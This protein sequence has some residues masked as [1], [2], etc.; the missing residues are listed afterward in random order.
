[1]TTTAKPP[2]FTLTVPSVS[3]GFKG[4]AP[5]LTV[6]TPPEYCSTWW[7]YDTRVP[8]TVWSDTQHNTRK[9][10]CQASGGGMYKPGVC[11]DGQELKQVNVIVEDMASTSLEPIHQGYCCPTN[12]K[13]YSNPTAVSPSCTSTLPGPVTATIQGASN[14][15]SSTTILSSVVT[16]VGE[17]I[18]LYWSSADLSLFQPSLAASLRVAMGLP[19]STSTSTSGSQSTPTSPASNQTSTPESG[20]GSSRSL[21]K[22]AIAG[23]SIGAALAALAFGFFGY[24]ASRHRSRDETDH[25]AT[26]STATMPSR[27]S[28]STRASRYGWIYRWR[29]KTVAET[30][31][32]EMD[33]GANVFKEYRGGSWRVELLGGS[34]SRSP[35]D[36]HEGKGSQVDPRMSQISGTTVVVAGPPLELEGSVPGGPEPL[37]GVQEEEVET[38]RDTTRP[39]H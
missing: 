15:D 16:V 9:S 1:M 23:I 8:G 4:A 19:P 12:F 11:P 3:D 39:V 38:N 31:I 30:D 29:K 5:L 17:P 33:S 24:L 7:F 28:M 34:H 32:P 37:P 21:S 25:G 10:Q 36:S 26:A 14:S 35:S 27:R 20:D 13:I 22:G 18:N 2:G 6:Y